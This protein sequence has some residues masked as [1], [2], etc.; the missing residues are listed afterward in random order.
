M[1]LSDAVTG[2]ACRREMKDMKVI[3][4]FASPMA[5][6]SLKGALVTGVVAV[7]SLFIGAPSPL[8]AMEEG[9][10]QAPEMEG[11]VMTQ[12]EDGDGDGDGV[13]ETHIRRYRNLSGDSVFSMTTKDTLWAWSMNAHGD[14]E[15]VNKNYVIRDSNCDGRFNERYS[16]DEEFRVPDCLKDTSTTK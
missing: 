11:F 10:Y 8:A 12:E 1:G 14:E 9:E 15:D 2:R 7:Y 16:L 13:N 5:R 3:P 4:R 6:D